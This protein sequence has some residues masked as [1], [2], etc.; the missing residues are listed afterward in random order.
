M[1]LV[2][3]ERES[4]S[5]CQCVLCPSHID[6]HRSIHLQ[7]HTTGVRC[8]ADVPVHSFPLCFHVYTWA[9]VSPRSIRAHRG[10]RLTRGGSDGPLTHNTKCQS[11]QEARWLWMLRTR[12]QTRKLQ[13]LRLCNRPA[14]SEANK[15]K[16]LI[17]VGSYGSSR[18]QISSPASRK[19]TFHRNHVCL[20][21]FRFPEMQK[22]WK[23]EQ[24][25]AI[26][27]SI[28]RPFPPQ[29]SSL[30][31]AGCRSAATLTVKLFHGSV[32]L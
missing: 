27:H 21:G 10:F 1:K 20:T 2:Q 18:L 8:P 22:H 23:Q 13:R 14:K 17:L 4:V 24:T 5:Q 31:A 6:C 28:Y 3:R 9:L 26:N 30:L 15:M 12:R 25:Y 11:W 16:D 32:S 29:P 7:L 19:N